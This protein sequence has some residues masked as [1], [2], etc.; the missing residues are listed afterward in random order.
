MTDVI[1]IGTNHHNTLGVLRSLGE[2]GIGSHLVL[3]SDA[4]SNCNYVSHSRYIDTLNILKNEAEVIP[5]L[6]QF[7]QQTNNKQV[8][9]ACSDGLASLIDLHS[10]K[11]SAFYYLPG[12]EKQ[13]KLTELMDK[14]EMMKIAVQSGLSIP[15]SVI[16]DK[17]KDKL[18]DV[19]MIYPCIIKPLVSK[20]SSKADIHICNNIEEL[21]KDVASTFAN[22][23][24]IQQFIEKEIE[25]QAIGCALADKV[26]IP[27]VTN[28]IRQPKTT[29]TGFLKYLSKK[30][31]SCDY[32]AINTFLKNTGY[33]GLFSA[34]F[35]RGTDGTDYF[36][37]INFRNDGNGICVQ[38]AG[39]NLPYLWYKGCKGQLIDSGEAIATKSGILVMPEVN[40][41]RH[42]LTREVGLIEWIKDVKRTSRFMEWDQKDPKPFYWLI[43][44]LIYRYWPLK[45]H[46]SSKIK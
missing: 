21:K 33:H 5:Y 41:F 37:E 43:I 27:G 36:M 45:I 23:L 14:G 16:F 28:I 15:K 29:N 18:Q 3:I 35:V 2:A 38:A 17:S 11:L 30:D 39:V 32:N 20:E 34:E 46:K 9:I 19:D 24:I 7:G 4:D 31:F 1:V 25:W 40:D 44:Q 10:G 26:L 8:L 6:L 42:V 12:V 13:G 22:R